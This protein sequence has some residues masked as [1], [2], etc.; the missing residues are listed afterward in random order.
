[1]NQHAID[2]IVD[3]LA[4]G[5]L[6]S[7]TVLL[8]V[9]RPGEDPAWLIWLRYLLLIVLLVLAALFLCLSWK[10]PWLALNANKWRALSHG[11]IALSFVSTQVPSRRVHS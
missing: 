6:V 1:M 3:S 8:H 11:M 10:A 2:A 4:T 7:Y 9:T 5:L